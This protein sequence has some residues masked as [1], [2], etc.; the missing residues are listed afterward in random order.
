MSAADVLIGLR[1]AVFC[2]I[3]HKNIDCYIGGI[4]HEQNL[5]IR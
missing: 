3:R 4:H 5:Y 2:D 1:A